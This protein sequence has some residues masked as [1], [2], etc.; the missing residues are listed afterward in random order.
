MKRFLA[1][2]VGLFVYFTGVAMQREQT[3]SLENSK[4]NYFLRLMSYNIRRKGHEPEPKYAWEKRLPL[5][6]ALI[7][8]V[9]PHLIGIQEAT[10]EQ[11][12]DLN[13]ALPEYASFGKGRG[14]SWFGW[15]TDEHTPIFYDTKR[16][17]LLE[18]GTFEINASEG[19]WMPWHA[20]QTG[21]LP[22]IVTWGIFKDTKTDKEF[23]LYNT[24]LDNMYEQARLHGLESI[25]KHMRSKQALDDLLPI[26]LMGDF[27]TELSKEVMAV[28]HAFEDAKQKAKVKEGPE[29]TRTGWEDAQ[30]KTI[31]HILLSKRSLFDV[32]RYQVIEKRKDA[33]YPSDHRPVVVDLVIK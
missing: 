27:N 3:P 31:D 10:D 24:H 25:A 23:Y 20:Q 6:E 1:V 32:M 29:Q 14:A 28:V 15:G 7:K 4:Q 18:N 26:V 30:L 17:E 19:Y 11:I 16:L 21:L 8:K 9:K 13:K 12:A 33:P 22:R 5:V 2:I